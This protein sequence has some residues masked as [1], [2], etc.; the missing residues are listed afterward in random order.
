MP[1]EPAAGIGRDRQSSIYRAGVS[2]RKPVVP[3]DF[4]TLERRAR[5]TASAEG[6]AYV[7][8]GAGDGATMRANRAAFDR[9]S[10]VPRMLRDV[11]RR[12]LGVELFGRRIPAPVLLAPVG[13]AEL[14][15]PEADL[16]VA[17]AAAELGLPYVFSNQACVPMEECA[18]AMGASPRWFQLYW[19]TDD[20]LVDSLLSR[21]QRCGAEAIVVTL[22]TT[23]LGWR[24]QDL[25]LGSLPFARGQGIAQYTSDPRFREMVRERVAGGAGEESDVRVTFSA[26][27]ALLSMSRRFPGPLLR[28]LRSPEPRAA[29]QTFL[30]TYSRPSLNWSDLATLR[31]RT[32]L[33]ILL[34]GVLHPDDARRAVDAGVDGVV[35]SNH[36]GRQVDGSVAALDALAEI[37]PVVD[38]E[39]TVLFDSGIRSGADVVKALALGADAVCLG[40]P[41]L[42]GLAL[43][44]AEGVRAVAANVLAELDLT[45]GLTGHASPAE[46]TRDALRPA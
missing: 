21:A 41:Y 1:D 16:A 44:G 22:D 37:A 17:K 34:K 9:W 31:N 38:G 36:G 2:G 19:S 24:P 39:L 33:P 14:I 12:D 26:I 27:R 20:D 43:A 11:S 5:R 13:A 15:H 7:A 10:I 28:N 40:R 8:G 30:D 32:S 42:Y 6:W 35:V 18:A 45:L 46:L 4:R 25:N 29:V 3:T 23:L